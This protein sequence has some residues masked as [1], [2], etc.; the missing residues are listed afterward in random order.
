MITFI[1]GTFVGA[2][3]GFVTAALCAAAQRGD[4]H[5]DTM[6]CDCH[7]FDPDKVDTAGM[8][9]EGNVDPQAWREYS[10]E[11]RKG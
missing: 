5:L 7:G 11:L 1:I 3:L 6:R 9:M 4:A 2:V 10:R 8:T